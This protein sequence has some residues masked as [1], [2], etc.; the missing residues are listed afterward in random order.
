MRIVQLS[1]SSVRYGI[2]GITGSILPGLELLLELSLSTSLGW[3]ATRFLLRVI[4]PSQ[5]SAIAVDSQYAMR[6]TSSSI[7]D[8]AASYSSLEYGL[9]LLAG[10]PVCF[11]ES[12]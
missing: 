2:S 7:V 10:F 8:T 12:V 6:S 9:A 4:V 3:T 5:H 11:S 1:Y